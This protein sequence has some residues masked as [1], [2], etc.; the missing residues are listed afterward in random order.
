MLGLDT[1]LLL[2]APAGE[3]TRCETTLLSTVDVCPAIRGLDFRGDPADGI[4][5]ATSLVHHV[6]LVT[7]DER[8]RRSRLVPLVT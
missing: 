3:L 1:H 6:P 8:I 5:G 4:I 2:L 7:R